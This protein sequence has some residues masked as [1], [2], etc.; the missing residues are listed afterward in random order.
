MS[1]LTSTKLI[2][3]HRMSQ[4]LSKPHNDLQYQTQLKEGVYLNPR[5]IFILLYIKYL[6]RCY[7]VANSKIAFC[8]CSIFDGFE[9]I[10]SFLFIS[11]FLLLFQILRTYFFELLLFIKYGRLVFFMI[12]FHRCPTFVIQLIFPHFVH[13]LFLSL[14][15]IYSTN[16]IYLILLN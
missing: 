3:A 12:L 16:I 8:H 5:L 14:K 15:R 6:N 13:P 4:N 10:S 7:T 1:P 9:H 11:L 2:L